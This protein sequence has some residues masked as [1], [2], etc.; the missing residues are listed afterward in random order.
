MKQEPASPPRLDANNTLKQFA[1]IASAMRL[2]TQQN[3]QQQQIHQTKTDLAAQL[4]FSSLLMQRQSLLLSNAHH[5]KSLTPSPSPP[6]THYPSPHDANLLSH[7]A[8]AYTPTAPQPKPVILE[9]RAWP[10]Y[11][12]TPEPVQTAPEDLRVVSRKLDFATAR[13][14][15]STSPHSSTSLSGAEE[16]ASSLSGRSSGFAAS[17]ADSTE[18]RSG[19][20]YAC[21]DCGKCYSTSSNLARHRQTHR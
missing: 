18:F 10:G 8:A 7:L 3:Q 17:A 16:D 6:L 5:A 12:S 21:P 4:F 9:K 19:N 1:E 13:V 14:P 2:D 15:A 11:V 20:E